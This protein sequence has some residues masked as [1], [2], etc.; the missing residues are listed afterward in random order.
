M[1]I[2]LIVILSSKKHASDFTPCAFI[3]ER[4]MGVVL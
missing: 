1:I 3:Y 4:A 2:L